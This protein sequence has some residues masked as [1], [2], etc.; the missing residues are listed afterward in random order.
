MKLLTWDKAKQKQVL[1]GN[2]VGNTIYRNVDSRH[3]MRI[4]DGYGMQEPAFQ[5]LIEN[6]V[7]WVVERVDPTGDMWR[8]SISDWIEHGKVMDYGHG[9]Q[10]FLSMKYMKKWHKYVDSDQAPQIA[11]E[12]KGRLSDIWHDKVRKGEIK[13]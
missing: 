13:L 11:Q 8:S 4:L 7:K 3:F 1:V 5:E 12:V 6:N 9:K 10:R 2:I